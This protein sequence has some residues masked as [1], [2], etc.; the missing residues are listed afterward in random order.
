MKGS[1]YRR[2][3]CRG[4]D[5]RPLGAKCP[6]LTSKRH[7]VWAVKQEL[8]AR[9]DGTRRAFHRSGYET[10]GKAQTDLDAVR[11]IL[12]VPDEDDRAGQIAIG[13]LLEAV[14]QDKKAPLPDLAV[15]KRRFLSDED[16]GAH[17]TVGEWLLEWIDGKT[18]R[19]TAI[20]RDR[21]NIRLHLVPH[22]GGRRLDRLRVKHLREMFDTIAERSQEIEEQNGLRREQ[23]ERCKWAHRSRPPESERERLAKEREILAGMPPFRRTQGPA[24]F[25]RIRSTLRAA[26]NDAMREQRFG[27]AVNVA[28]LLELDWK[29][30]KGQLWTDA[31]VQ[32]WRETGEK[33]SSV[34]VWTPDQ[35]GQ[36]LT[37]AQ[38]DRLYALWHLIAF[39]GLRR[40]EACGVRWDDVDLVAG[41]LTVAKA[42]VQNG[43]T[44]Y[45]GEPKTDAG[46]RTIGLD[47]A[48]VEALRR[49]KA[50]Q[51]RERTRLGAGWTDTGRVFTEEDGSWLRPSDVTQTFNSMVRETG[52]PPVRLH[53]LRHGA[54]TLMHASGGDMHYIK[55]TLGHSSHHF[56]SDTYTNLLPQVDREIAEKAVGLV[57][58]G[59]RRT[60]GHASV[61]QTACAEKSEAA[62]RIDSAGS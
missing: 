9:E 38:G 52:L 16:L 47:S 2:C 27:L 59:V 4:E 20:Q 43:W 32:R 13:D 26:L 5:G 41:T 55:T 60:L 54:A 29:R 39:R 21:D 46:A 51:K 1:T 49:Q 10:A 42:L 7:G 6:K 44:V 58:I 8:P 62:V 23:V 61:A 53:D 17:T 22:I 37:Y 56:T 3:Y 50:R 48:T 34:M 45:E 30:P 18:G 57:P 35:V 15:V 33:P 25:Q 36:F 12:E 31:A 28:A 40:G 24:S 11:A 19:P 14:S